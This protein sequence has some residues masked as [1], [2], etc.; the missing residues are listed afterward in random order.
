MFPASLTIEAQVGV[1]WKGPAPVAR[2]S[3]E[4]SLLC[5]GEG[6]EGGGGR[7]GVQLIQNLAQI[8]LTWLKITGIKLVLSD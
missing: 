5:T 6:G 8:R 1:Q 3:P 4:S 2:A 7:V